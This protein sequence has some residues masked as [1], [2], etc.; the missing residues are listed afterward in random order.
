MSPS[1]QSRRCDSRQITSGLPPEADI[2]G[3]G[4]HVSNAPTAEVIASFNHLIEA[5]VK[6]RGM[7]SFLKL[8]AKVL[9]P[10]ACT[11]A[12]TLD[13]GVA[14]DAPNSQPNATVEPSWKTCR[15]P[16]SQPG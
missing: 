10:F 1:D 7:L 6:C 16:A 14:I 9:E 5:N 4:R 3:V 2:F 8:C 15:N 13:L 12:E 11:A